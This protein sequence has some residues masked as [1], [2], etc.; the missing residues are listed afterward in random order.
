MVFSIKCRIIGEVL[1]QLL[2]VD[3][4]MDWYRKSGSH[5]NSA[6]A[7]QLHQPHKQNVKAYFVLM[8]PFSDEALQG[9]VIKKMVYS[10]NSHHD[11]LTLFLTHIPFKYLNT[12]LKWE[13]TLGSLT[14]IQ[15]CKRLDIS[16]KESKTN[17]PQSPL[18][19][20]SIYTTGHTHGNTLSLNLMGNCDQTPER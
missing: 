16:E 3:L 11:F 9:Q 5:F 19:I 15:H 13:T 18:C 14:F 2:E 20:Y 4:W 10:V 12:D 6:E 7:K 8:E 1:H 17:P